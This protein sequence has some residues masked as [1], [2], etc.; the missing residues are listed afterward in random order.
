MRVPPASDYTR[1][2]AELLDI[3]ESVMCPQCVVINESDT[4]TVK[5]VKTFILAWIN[6]KA[7]GQSGPPEATFDSNQQ[8]SAVP[9][10]LLSS[11]LKAAHYL[12]D[13]EF[14][15]TRTEL[16]ISKCSKKVANELLRIAEAAGGKP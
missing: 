8:I 3:H 14:D 5:L 7:T 16:E 12:V 11:A 6:A 9:D 2:R 10:E 1:I 13:E 4:Y 15:G